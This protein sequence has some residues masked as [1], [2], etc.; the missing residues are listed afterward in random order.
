[1][2]KNNKWKLVV[3]SILILLPML[4]ALLCSDILPKEIVVHW[5]LD[6]TP[7]GFASAALFFLVMPPVMLAVHWGCMI[8]SAVLERK[9]TTAQNKKL[10]AVA[11]W[12]IPIISLVVSGTIFAASIGQTANIYAL[13]CIF[14]AV[15]FIYI[16]NYL[17]K[18]TRNLTMGIKLK[19]TLENDENWNATHRFSGK[20]YVV[21]GFLCLLAIPLPP[22][23]FPF[24]CIGVIL[25]AAVLPTLY[26]YFFY[27][28][29]IREGTAT[30]EDYQAGHAEI[31]KK[32]KGATV[33][34]AIA[35][36]ITLVLVGILMFTGNV[37][38]AFTDTT[39]TIEATYWSDLTLAYEDI[40]AVEYYEEGIAGT[41]V[42]GYASARLLLGA[43]Q[44]DELGTYTRY[45]YT[46]DGPCILL[47]VGTRTIVLGA[48]NAQ[49]TKAIYDRLLAELA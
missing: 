36:P 9:N 27:K 46:G 5:G 18:T 20:V 14:F 31:I 19:W 34:T 42:S 33:A 32:N 3:S 43:F 2:M 7:D 16:G 25:A 39:F 24:V 11:F 17:P 44:N 47:R 22:K 15:L 12:I 8:L 21:V 29:Q 35:V 10:S 30:K 26:S 28:K 37:N 38:T 23:A 49:E 41:R 48:Q 40:D 4:L 13:I 1:M 45:T 6:G